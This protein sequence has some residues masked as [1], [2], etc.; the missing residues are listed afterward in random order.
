MNL[1]PLNTN[2]LFNR[3]KNT[4]RIEKK[5]LDNMLEALSVFASS[6]EALFEYAKPYLPEEKK[7]GLE[8]LINQI[9]SIMAEFGI[10]EVVEP[11]AS[12]SEPGNTQ[13]DSGL[14]ESHQSGDNDKGGQ[15]LPGD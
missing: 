1:P 7:T 2:E 14:V 5:M 6:T 8:L 3:R 11:A 4:I 13:P 10:T 15:T 12:I 9:P